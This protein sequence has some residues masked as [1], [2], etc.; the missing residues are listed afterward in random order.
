MGRIVRSRGR[1]GQSLVQVLIAFG[2]L[3]TLSLMFA[4]LYQNSMLAQNTVRM[5][6]DFNNLGSLISMILQG[7]VSCSSNVNSTNLASLTFNR[8][9]AMLATQ[10]ITVNKLTYPNGDVL[11]QNGGSAGN[12]LTI[13]D[14]RINQFH[15]LV[16]GTSYLAMVHMEI[17]KSG[18]SSVGSL[19]L[20]KDFP[21]ALQTHVVSGTTVQLD[22]CGIVSTDQ[23]WTNV[24]SSRA[25]GATYT[26]T[27]GRPIQV[28][29][30]LRPSG[31]PSAYA[32]FHIDGV[33]AFRA[34]A[35][36]GS[37]SIPSLT[38]VVPPGSTYR[39]S[40]ALVTLDPTLSFS[41][42]EFR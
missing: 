37:G 23:Q 41:W 16:A 18:A 24:S 39:V 35:A 26:N 20:K 8:N 28:T 27:T 17:T 14:F 12:G 34:D 7:S 25:L 42:S 15:E 21:I 31:A 19:V 30:V 32:E 9:P 13:S 38:A 5:N 40:G 33:L 2:L 10:S 11:A 3:G 4:Q 29:V 6:S 36:P 22:A 1:S